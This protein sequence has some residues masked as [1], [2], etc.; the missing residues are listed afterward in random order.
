MSLDVCLWNR[1]HFTVLVERDMYRGVT[2]KLNLHIYSS[3]VET[4][5]AINVSDRYTHCRYDVNLICIIKF[6]CSVNSWY[7]MCQTE[8]FWIENVSERFELWKRRITIKLIRCV[9]WMKLTSE[10]HLI[11]IE[12]SVTNANDICVWCVIIIT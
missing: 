3:G 9:N 7:K 5:T 4:I 12:Q 6:L 2:N 8:Y 1:I 10:N 11:R